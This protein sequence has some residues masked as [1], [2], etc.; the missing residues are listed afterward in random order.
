MA[1]KS[2][3]TKQ[4]I[5][6]QPPDIPE[7]KENLVELEEKSYGTSLPNELNK[8]I[9]K[10]DAELDDLR[11][12]L[13]I[14]NN[15]VKSS[16][17]HLSDKGSDLTAKVSETY[18]QLGTLDDAY[19]SLSDKSATISK[20]IKAVTKQISRVSDKS[21]SDFN[22]LNDGY[23]ALLARTD[24]LTKKSNET[25]QT[26]N[27]SIKDNA[28]ILQ[29]LETALVAEI[30]S[31]AES[32]KERDQN[33]SEKSEQISKNLDKT[34]D[35][36][37]ASHA[38]MLKMQAVDQALEKRVTEVG[39]AAEELTS[40]SRELSRST[41]LLTKQS[42]ELS[43]AIDELRTRAD[44]HDERISDLQE[45]TEK[46]AKALVSLMKVEKR[47]FRT[48][49]AMVALLVIGFLVFMGYEYVNWKSEFLTNTALRSDIATTNS[50]L[51]TTHSQLSQ[52]GEKALDTQKI[53][54]SEITNIHEKLVSIA[55][56][57]DTLD[58]RVT[59]MA[60]HR[61]LGNGN[62]I[63]G[64]E[65]I[66]KQPAGN[67]AI[68]LATFGDKQEIY[69]LAER[70]H[71]YLKDDLA[72]LPVIVRNTQRYALIYGNYPDMTDAESALN[73]LPRMIE[74]QRPRVHSMKQIQSFI[75]Q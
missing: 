75:T 26:L 62:S 6:T 16:L 38:R 44:G 41:T 4:P 22:L 60:P 63:H 30:A 47:H 2:Q 8:K 48:L 7:Q 55:D 68:H 59:N 52:L 31:L 64:A 61:T 69:K 72:Y 53:M 29:E 65:W 32:T 19:K 57:V 18:Q 46:G 13:S 40:K 28:Q 1:Q 33:L 12:E 14:T 50:Q 10:I 58:G 23:Q 37:K 34:E 27:V 43:E 17:S 67:H 54:H 11:G 3:V 35:E 70:Y 39:D 21:D 42:T 5:A 66:S 36:L 51:D 71:I 24:E 45:R 25:T 20:E 49:G 9:R 73:R 15:S 56:Q 74:R